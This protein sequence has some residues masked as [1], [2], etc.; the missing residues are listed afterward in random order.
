MGERQ[1]M[2]MEPRIHF[3]TLGV[4]DWANAVRFYRDGLGFPLSSSSVDDVAFFRLGGLVLALYP[5]DKLA[6]DAIVSDEGTGFRGIALAHNVRQREDV[7][8]VLDLAVSAGGPAWPSTPS[9]STAR[10]TSTSSIP[11][12]DPVDGPSLLRR[13]EAVSVGYGTRW[14]TSCN[15]VRERAIPLPRTLCRARMAP[16]LQPWTGLA[17]V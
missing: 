3:I 16:C 8:R 11:R 6:A 17:D 1:G 4:R 14:R 7:A 12:S 5:W 13:L 9:D 10:S 2:K 15:R